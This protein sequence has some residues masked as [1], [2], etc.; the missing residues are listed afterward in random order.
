MKPALLVAA[1]L[2]CAAL[3]C[4][5]ELVTP[6]FLPGTTSTGSTGATGA[7]GLGVGGAG[8]GGAAVGGGGTGGV[9]EAW[10]WNLP[11]GFP[12]PKVPAGNPMSVAKVELGRRLLY[13]QRL[14]G[15]Q[16]QACASC[17]RQERAFTD[18]LAQAVGAT[19][20]VHP[21]GAMSLANVAYL[22]VLTWAHPYM[23]ELEDQAV[24]P[25]FDDEPVQLGLSSNVDQ[26]LLARL[27]AEPIYPPMFV[28]AFPEAAQPLSL[29]SVVRA[30][31]AFERTLISGTSP[32]DRWQYGGQ[33]EAISDAAK[34]GHDLFDSEKL[35]CFQCHSGF[36]FQDSNEYEG[37]SLVDVHF[38]NTGLYNIDGMGAYPAPNTGIHALTQKPED[39][40]KFRAPTLRNI[41]VTAPYMHDG[42]AATLDDVLEHYAAAGRTIES[43]PNAGDGSENPYKSDFLVGFEL[44]AEERADLHAFFESLTDEAFLSDPQHAD[45]WQLPQK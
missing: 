1:W 26:E 27:A 45:P 31:A 17:H 28:E 2:S 14:S 3:G 9:P 15:N 30:L 32:F 39:M 29:Q 13:D 24:V 21:R 37:K 12:V 34:R 35:E 38:H 7:G 19:G 10:A 20:Q 36:N 23:F 16:S 25:M 41:A 8:G 4:G 18:D 5:D 44:T 40:G 11:T 33:E 6:L 43:G 22:T 42:S